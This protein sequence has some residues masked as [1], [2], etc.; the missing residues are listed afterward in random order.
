MDFPTT[1]RPV[2]AAL[3]QAEVQKPPTSRAE[4]TLLPAPLSVDEARAAAETAFEPREKTAIIQALLAQPPASTA[5]LSLA[6]QIAKQAAA[7]TYGHI[8]PRGPQP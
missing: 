7:V 6:M 5:A 3:P 1:T 4:T 8:A 2:T